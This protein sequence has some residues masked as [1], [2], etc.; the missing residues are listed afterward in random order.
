MHQFQGLAIVWPVPSGLFHFACR[1]EEALLEHPAQQ[2]QPGTSPSL[3]RGIE[4][5]VPLARLESEHSSQ[6][7]QDPARCSCAL[8]CPSAAAKALDQAAAACLAQDSVL[9]SS[10]TPF[11]SGVGTGE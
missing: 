10:A 5:M 8:H 3:L 2:E 7:L 9:L 1:R 6:D 4:L 11:F